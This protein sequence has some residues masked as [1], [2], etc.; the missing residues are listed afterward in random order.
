MAN[1]PETKVQLDRCN[2][3]DEYCPTCKADATVH[4]IKGEQ[5]LCLRHFLM[6]EKARE[7]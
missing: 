4:D 3:S 2:F 7:L 5:N 6:V 1:E